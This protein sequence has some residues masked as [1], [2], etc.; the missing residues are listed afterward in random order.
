MTNPSQTIQKILWDNT[1]C[2][3]RCHWA[4]MT[5]SQVPN[6]NKKALWTFVSGCNGLRVEVSCNSNRNTRSQLQH[7]APKWRCWCVSH[8]V[9]FWIDPKG[10]FVLVWK[11]GC[12]GQSNLD[13]VIFWDARPP[14]FCSLLQSNKTVLSAIVNVIS[15]RNYM[16]SW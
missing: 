12:L 8:T 7:G 14:P 4:G 11:Q 13:F 1:K 15:V 10:S 3:W 16:A 6:L 9:T 5:T 2:P